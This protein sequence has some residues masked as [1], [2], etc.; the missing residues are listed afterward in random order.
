M[1]RDDVEVVG[2]ALAQGGRDAEAKK[3]F[4][5]SKRMPLVGHVIIAAGVGND[6]RNGE[7]AGRSIALAGAGIAGTAAAVGVLAL[8]G[9]SAPVLVVAAVGVGGAIVTTKLAEKYVVDTERFTKV[10]EAFD[11]GAAKV[12]SKMSGGARL[13]WKAIF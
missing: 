2:E 6:I 1:D 10:T 11:D 5:F 12:A 4:T 7:S 3:A 8:V 9:V 13:V